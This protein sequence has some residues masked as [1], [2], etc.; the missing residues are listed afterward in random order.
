MLR[1]CLGV[2]LVLFLW[3][4]VASAEEDFAPTPDAVQPLLVGQQV[5]ALTLTGSD[6]NTFDLN[7]QSKKKPLVVVFYRGHW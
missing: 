3:V 5:P 2:V 7:A 4:G 6:G 1:K